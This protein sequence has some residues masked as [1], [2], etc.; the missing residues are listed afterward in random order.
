MPPNVV[1][2]V[3]SIFF[4][5]VYGQTPE[6]VDEILPEVKPITETGY[7]N[8]TVVYKQEDQKVC[9]QKNSVPGSNIPMDI[10]EDE[11]IIISNSIS[12]GNKEDSGQ[13]K[14]DILKQSSGLR[15][16]FT[17]VVR[18]LSEEDSGNYTCYIRQQNQNAATWPRKLGFLMV[19]VAPVISNTM[20]TV[21]ERTIGGNITLE[22]QAFGKPS[23]NITWKREDGSRL[24]NGNFQYRG[25]RLQLITLGK[26]DRG[27]Y[28]CVADN[29]VRP[30]AS[31][32]VQVRIFYAPTCRAVQDTVGQA[33]NRRFNSKLECIVEGYPTPSMHW[34]KLQN[35]ARV[36]ISDGDDYSTEKLSSSQNLASD[37]TWYVLTVKNVQ[38]NDYTEYYCVARNVY[39]TNQTIIRLFETMECQ[40]PNCPSISTG[41][42]NAL[43]ACALTFFSTLISLIILRLLKY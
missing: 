10:S 32:K 25:A 31:F 3:V 12:Q 4:V 26:K 20:E 42:S 37:T 27:N 39:G 9:W 8:C 18:H 22:C 19:Q 5:T 16:R 40:G 24:P 35:G 14:Y 41:G 34:E 38:A 11:R 2:F 17:L 28:I 33:Q 1:I 36:Q 29:S 6:I 13:P 30:P 23:P 21:Y 15:T 7:L 43:C